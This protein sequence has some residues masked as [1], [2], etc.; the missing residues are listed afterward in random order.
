MIKDIGSMLIAQ[1]RLWTSKIR[2]GIVRYS[3]ILDGKVDKDR[4]GQMSKVEYSSEEC[5]F[6][7]LFHS[8]LSLFH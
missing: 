5:A 8:S 1:C 3:K 2:E 4:Q 7:L 6:I